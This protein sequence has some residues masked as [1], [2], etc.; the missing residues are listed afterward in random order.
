[1]DTNGLVDL[2][3]RNSLKLV[4]TNIPALFGDIHAENMIKAIYRPNSNKVESSRKK[5]LADTRPFF[6][7]Q[8]LI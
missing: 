7:F 4:V 5:R 8:E 1:V 6:P 2:N 3:N